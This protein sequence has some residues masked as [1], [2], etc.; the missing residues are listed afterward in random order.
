M[1]EQKE[2]SKEANKQNNKKAQKSGGLISRFAKLDIKKKIQYVGILLVI[3]VILTIY[4]ASFSD[5]SSETPAE[6]TATLAVDEDDI[7]A[8]LKQTLSRIEGAGRVEV[9]ITYESSSEIVPAISVDKQ[10]STTTDTDDGGSS[11]TN[12]EN[13]QSEIV[14]MNTGDG[15]A[16]LVLREESPVVKGVIVVA[17][18]ADD[19]G[20]KLNLLNAVQTIL[21]ISPDQVDVYKMNIE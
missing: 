17:E 16:A 13:T 8:K 1:E 4:F 12:S 11:T 2:N 18:G 5:S 6:Q 15:S 10:T 3:V 9:M 7:E 21:N 14:T 20:V 19:I